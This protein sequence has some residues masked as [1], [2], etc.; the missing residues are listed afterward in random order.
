MDTNSRYPI[1][2]HYRWSTS[3]FILIHSG[4]PATVYPPPTKTG[5]GKTGTLLLCFVF[6][7]TDNALKKSSAKPTQ[8]APPRM[9]DFSFSTL[10]LFV[11]LSYAVCF[12]ILLSCCQATAN[13]SFRLVHI[14]HNSRL[15]SQTRVHLHQTFCHIFKYGR[16]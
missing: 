2:D 1:V 8:R 6:F 13:V 7:V 4:S 10:H 15:C 5:A 12:L 3:F 16:H 14:Q 11:V 9:T